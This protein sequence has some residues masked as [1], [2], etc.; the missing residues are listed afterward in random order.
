MA[1]RQHPIGQAA[2]IHRWP[3]GAS[4]N[5]QHNAGPVD[6]RGKEACGQDYLSRVS[7]GTVRGSRLP[8]QKLLKDLAIRM[9]RQLHPRYDATPHSFRKGLPQ[10]V[11]GLRTSRRRSATAVM[12]TRRSGSW[13]G[14]RNTVGRT[15]WAWSI[16]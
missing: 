12:L 4:M 2:N 7:N 5:E 8:L 3:G 14:L 9:P 10:P 16:C 11:T 6:V 1:A 13:P 15:R